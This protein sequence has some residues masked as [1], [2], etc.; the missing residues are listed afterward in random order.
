MT[1]PVWADA[2]KSAHVLRLVRFQRQLAFLLAKCVSIP[3][4]MK[5]TNDAL[6]Y[7]GSMRPNLTGGSKD[8][9]YPMVV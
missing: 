1:P 5:R 7:V 8:G 2:G 4:L 6:S 9:G 3:K